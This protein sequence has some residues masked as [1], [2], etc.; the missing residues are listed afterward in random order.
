MSGAEVRTYF[1]QRNKEVLKPGVMHQHSFLA[2]LIEVAGDGQTAKGV[3]D[4]IGVDTGSGDSMANWG[5]VRYAIDFKK[6]KDEWK[7]WH[8]KV[9]PLWNAPYGEAWSTMV[10]KASKGAMSGGGAS[11]AAA[12]QGAPAPAAGG[13]P[14]RATGAGPAAGQAPGGAP[15]AAAAKWRYSGTDDTPVLPANPPKPYYSFDPQ[16]AY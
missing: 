1:E 13:P 3:W 15:A 8:M 12:T 6:I 7:I 4:S 2:P 16:D 5:W 10:Q 9:I 11:A 14:P